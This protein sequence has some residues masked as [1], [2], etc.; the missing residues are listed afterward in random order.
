MKKRALTDH[1]L[2][3]EAYARLL[4]VKAQHA[5]NAVYDATA[6]PA[7]LTPSTVEEWLDELDALLEDMHILTDAIGR[8]AGKIRDGIKKEVCE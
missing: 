6:T 4:R 3:L 1:V 8:A 5:Y 7:K 2:Q